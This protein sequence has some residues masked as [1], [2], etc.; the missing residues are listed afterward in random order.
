M[1]CTAMLQKSHPMLLLLLLPPL[2]PAAAAAAISLLLLRLSLS[3]G[4]CLYLGVCVGGGSGE[5]E[6]QDKQQT[7]V[8]R[9][10]QERSV[11]ALGGREGA[12]VCSQ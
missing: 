5:S 8:N 7:G 4:S 6:R 10:S 2:L 3:R 9:R 11:A 12:A 1:Y